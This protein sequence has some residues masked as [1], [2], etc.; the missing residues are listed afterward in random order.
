V[1]KSQ[2]FL[3]FKKLYFAFSSRFFLP[4]L[5]LLF[6]FGKSYSLIH[7]YS[8]IEFLKSSES[9]KSN[10]GEEFKDNSLGISL[11]H[12]PAKSGEEIDFCKIFSGF[13]SQNL[14]FLSASIVIS[15]L[16]FPL[17]LDRRNFSFAKISYR[18]SSYYSQ[19]PPRFS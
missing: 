2:N 13:T 11:K 3:Q 16:A 9:N 6:F 8:H 15:F 18:N 17:I 12:S 1:F 5:F 4:I 10:I 19:A 7:D 14:L